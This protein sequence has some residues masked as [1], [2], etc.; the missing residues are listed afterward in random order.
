[1][2]AKSFSL[3]A[4]AIVSPGLIDGSLRIIEKALHHGKAVMAYSG[5]KDAV[6]TSLLL[7]QFGVI[8]GLCETS[9]YFTRQKADVKKQA[10]AMGLNISYREKLNLQWLS[11][12]PQFVF[13]ND[14]KN[15]NALCQVRQ[16]DSA[17]QYALQ[18][19]YKVVI[20]GRKNQGNCVPKEIYE[21]RNGTVGAHPL[22]YWT[23]GDV[24][25]YLRDNGIKRPW[26]YSTPFGLTEGNAPWILCRQYP[27]KYRNYQI[28]F[29]MEPD[30]VIE[31][32]KY[33]ISGAAEFLETNSKG[34]LN[35]A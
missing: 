22:K 15:F 6:A 4:K 20:T 35:H 23:D 19:G 16:R 18:N 25:A 30:I 34:G 26:I 8:D 11:T 28:I 24:W 9:F 32:A 33:G 17:E 12:H 5:G 3:E 27:D 31:A 2:G 7:K 1:M 14:N 13:S 10:D 29:G 21:R